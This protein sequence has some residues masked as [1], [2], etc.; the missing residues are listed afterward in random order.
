MFASSLQHIHM[1][2]ITLLP[3]VWD[4]NC[5]NSDII[6]T[7]FLGQR[8]LI[9]NDFLTKVLDGM[10]FAGFVSE[11]GQPYR[12][13]DLFDEVPLNY[14]WRHFTPTFLL[15][16]SGLVTSGRCEI[17]FIGILFIYKTF[18]CCFTGLFVIIVYE[19]W[20]MK[21]NFKIHYFYDT[22]LV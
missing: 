13:C 19:Q 20:I 22:K 21:R 4:F 17:C 6:Q 9:E 7:A 14:K 18:E 16:W 10:A 12:A 5:C 2:R 1:K 11:R 15:H 3:S 8:G